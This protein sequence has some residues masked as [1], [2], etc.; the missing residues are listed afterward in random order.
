MTHAM[1][2]RSAIVHLPPTSHSFPLD[3]TVSNSPKARLAWA[4][5]ALTLKVGLATAPEMGVV[6]PGIWLFEID[7]DVL[8][9]RYWVVLH[10]THRSQLACHS[11]QR[12]CAD[13]SLGSAIEILW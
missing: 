11:S 10:S 9:K 13:F 5:Y 6:N 4:L 2:A 8:E 12:S 3:S 7:A 1:N